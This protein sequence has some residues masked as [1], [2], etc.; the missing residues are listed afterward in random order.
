[1]LSGETAAGAFPAKSVEVMAR[2]VRSTE[3]AI[4]YS[5]WFASYDLCEKSV[6]D[7]ISHATCSTAYDLRAAAIITVT[8]TGFT[9]R[10]ISKFRPS[11][12]IIGCSPYDQTFRQLNLSWGVVPVKMEKPANTDELFENAVKCATETGIVKKSDLVVITAGVPV[13]VSGTTNILK[14]VIV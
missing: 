12:P 2:I 8:E 14:V 10:M 7:A 1:M 11:C 6:T 3:S 5:K 13:G 9:A 4:D